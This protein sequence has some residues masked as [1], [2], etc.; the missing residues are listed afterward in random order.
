MVNDRQLWKVLS[1][2]Y[3]RVGDVVLRSEDVMIAGAV[4]V[5]QI[6]YG[7]VDAALLTRRLQTL[8]VTAVN[9]HAAPA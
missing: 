9:L 7:H 5:H 4:S 1:G 8:G 3:R 6:G 2:Y